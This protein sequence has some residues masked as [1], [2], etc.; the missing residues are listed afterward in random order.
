[1]NPESLR[2]ELTVALVLKVILLV[3][4]W[5]VIFRFGGKKAAPQADIAEQFQL[6]AAV[7]PTQSPPSPKENPHVR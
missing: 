4:L 1:L 7:G 6:P 5:F 3:A 2:F